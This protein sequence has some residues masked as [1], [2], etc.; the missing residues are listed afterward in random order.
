[1]ATEKP[2]DADQGGG[3]SVI[4]FGHMVKF[5]AEGNRIEPPRSGDPRIID[6]LADGVAINVAEVLAFARGESLW[7]GER[8]H[9]TTGYDQD[10]HR[11]WFNSRARAFVAGQRHPKLRKPKGRGRPRIDPGKLVERELWDRY[12]PRLWVVKWISRNGVIPSPETVRRHMMAGCGASPGAR[13]IER[14]AAYRRLAD[15][16]ELVKLGEEWDEAQLSVL[17]WTGTDASESELASLQRRE[18]DNCKEWPDIPDS[19]HISALPAATQARFTDPGVSRADDVAASVGGEDGPAKGVCYGRQPWPLKN[20]GYKSRATGLKDR[21]RPAR[22]AP[23]PFIP[24]AATVM[25]PGCDVL[26][27]DP[28][29]VEVA[30][31]DAEISRRTAAYWSQ[32]CPEGTKKQRVNIE[33]N[34]YPWYAPRRQGRHD[35]EL[36]GYRPRSARL[37]DWELSRLNRLYLAGILSQADY[38][39]VV[40][41]ASVARRS[42]NFSED[43]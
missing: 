7:L 36:V 11:A 4:V 30:E 6:P 39:Q 33:M 31:A 22:P 25:P 32:V 38:A 24:P 5:D 27:M 1:V 12:K 13:A 2:N 20:R 19:I 34:Q 16:Y 14:S 29:P 18:S 37:H 35:P 23:V 40:C 28:R 41:P 3:G 10:K 17:I 9:G 21:K 43:M 42:R 15:A 8:G 26:T